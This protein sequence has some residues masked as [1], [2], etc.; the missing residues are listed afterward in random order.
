[1]IDCIST[2]VDSPITSFGA[3]WNTLMS[4]KGRV[5]WRAS[6]KF[7][8]ENHYKVVLALSQYSMMF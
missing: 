2:Y 7:E 1:M 5:R 4:V 8:G 3:L 6:T